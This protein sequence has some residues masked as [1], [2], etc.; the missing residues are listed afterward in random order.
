MAIIR[1]METQD[2]ATGIVAKPKQTK[3]PPQLV[4]ALQALGLGGKRISVPA[5]AIDP[6][7]V[8]GVEK[9]LSAM[10]E[11][12]E[13][14]GETF[15]TAS[16]KPGRRSGLK[17]P[18]V[19]KILGCGHRLAKRLRLAAK[20]KWDQWSYRVESPMVSLLIDE[21]RELPDSTVQILYR[22]ARG[23]ARQNI[24]PL[25]ILNEPPEMPNLE[26]RHARV[27]AKYAQQ[28]VDSF[29]LDNAVMEVM[30]SQG[31]GFQQPPEGV[32]PLA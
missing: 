16:G 9:L 18:E 6:K 14:E 24:D 29:C 25:T 7:E 22:K 10:V 8:A 5:K 31:T 11:R 17:V 32:D 19:M 15:L 26:R 3:L 28:S 21:L 20:K 27:I 2:P 30:N 12:Y 23:A 4:A 1:G 13:G